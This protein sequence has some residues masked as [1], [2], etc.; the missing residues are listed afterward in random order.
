MKTNRRWMMSIIK[1]AK[2]AKTKMPW[3][4]GIRRGATI[5]RRM[6]PSFAQPMRLSA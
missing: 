1:E 3:E 4:R 2:E 6:T 5:A